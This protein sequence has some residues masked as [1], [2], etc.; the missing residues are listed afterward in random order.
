[1]GAR[2]STRRRLRVASIIF[3]SLRTAGGYQVFTYNLLK[4][5]AERGHRVHLY[6]T[7]REYRRNRSFYDSTSFAVGPLFFGNQ[8]SARYFPW[9]STA[10]LRLQHALKR[11]DVWQIV[12]SYPAG[13]LASSLSGKVPLVLRT[14]GDDIQKDENL[15]YGLRLNPRLERLISKTVLRMDRVV[16]MT[17]AIA[18][19]YRELDVPESRIAEIPNGVDVRRFAARSDRTQTR[20]TWGLPQDSFLVLTVGRHHPKKGYT[21]IPQIARVLKAKGASF[22]WL[23]VGANT[24][25]LDSLIAQ[26]GVSDVVR[27]ER[28]IRPQ[29]S[30]QDNQEPVIPGDSLVRLYQCADV[31]VFPSRLEGFPRVLIEAMAAGL[32][33]VTTDAPGCKDVVE[34]GKTGLVAIPGDVDQTAAQINQLI[35]DHKLR[36]RLISNGRRHAQTYDWDIVVDKYEELY[37]SLLAYRH[38]RDRRTW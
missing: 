23:V 27:T 32:P 38:P 37:R 35:V 13:Y 10:Y 4:R 12:G 22:F 24:D 33:V 5:L 34:H 11:Y 29:R 31:F 20:R 25:R 7:G 26:T 14:H 28:E 3:G 2:D 6:V 1:M 8:R 17:Q 19:C 16:A 30:L 21:D 9:V 36:R 15:N 18:D